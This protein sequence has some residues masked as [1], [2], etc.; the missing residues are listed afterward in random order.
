MVIYTATL[1]VAR[2]KFAVG[3]SGVM[4]FKL[5]TTG[6]LSYSKTFTGDDSTTNFEWLQSELDYIDKDQVKVKVNNVLKTL[7]TDYTFPTATKITFNSAPDIGDTILVYI[8]EW[9]NLNPT[10]DANNYLAND[11]PLNE[12]TVFTIPIH[13][14]TKNFS[15]RVFNDSPF[16]VSLNSMMWEG[17]YS[18]RY[19]RRT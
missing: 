9:Y 5:K 3:L 13:Q 4:S 19:Y 14:K 10:S 11:V 7:G 6:R 16:P 2:M 17:N 1:T 8:D 18:P 15:L 12:D